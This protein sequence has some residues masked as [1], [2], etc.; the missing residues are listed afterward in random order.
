MFTLLKNWYIRRFS[1]PQAVAFLTLLLFAIFIFYFFSGILAPLFIAIILA[2][3]LEYPIS[4]LQ[5]LRFPR[6]LSIILVLCTTFGIVF[7]ILF[8]IFPILWSQLV[9]LVTD[10]P[11]MFN[12]TNNW[13]LDLPNHYPA[14]TD[15]KMVD[16]LFSSLKNKILGLAESALGF[17]VSS[18]INLVS[19]GIYAF[20][21]PFMIFFLLKDKNDLIDYVL[22][23]LP[24]DQVLVKKV[25]N[26]MQIQIANYIRGKLFEMF[27]MTIVTYFIFL[28]FQLNYALLLAVV[29]GISVLI[30]YIGIVIVSIPVAIVAI[31][32]FGTTPTF[33]YLM[34][35]YITAQLL[36]GNVVVP[37]LFSEAVNLTPLTIMV[38]VLI[39]GGIWGFWGVF[40]AIPLATFI[41][42]I[43]TSWPSSEDVK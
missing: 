4:L 29:V 25:W 6:L 12:Q 14:L 33:A 39:F 22:Q 16:S 1:D 21:V 43:V 3:L 19:L 10:L 26:E 23:Y 37:F 27:V 24:R 15:Y 13:L 31:F 32:Q 20:L 34:I 28:Y 11:T 30:P 18:L 7:I 40:F 35:A 5:K 42:A 17:S 41:K 2:Y 38:A 9:K 8:G 36:D